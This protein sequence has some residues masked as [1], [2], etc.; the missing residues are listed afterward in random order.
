MQCFCDTSR[1][2]LLTWE[3]KQCRIPQTSLYCLKNHLLQVYYLHL[4]DTRAQLQRMVLQT[5]EPGWRY[6]VPAWVVT[7]AKLDGRQC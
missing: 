4:Q 2:L 6:A 7:D 5:A 1:L 3:A